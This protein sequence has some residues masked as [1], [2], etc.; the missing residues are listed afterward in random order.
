M[1]KGNTATKVGNLYEIEKK[2]DEKINFWVEICRFQPKLTIY[3]TT[4]PRCPFPLM[5]SCQG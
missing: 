3:A 4:N 1:P 5:N 2:K